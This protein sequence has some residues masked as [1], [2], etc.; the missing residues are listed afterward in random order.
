MIFESKQT[1][2]STEKKLN[3]FPFLKDEG[4]T[5]KETSK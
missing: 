2:Q 1:L 5:N 4:K 3:P